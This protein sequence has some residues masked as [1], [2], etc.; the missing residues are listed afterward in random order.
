MYTPNIH[1]IRLYTQEHFKLRS[2]KFL[3][4]YCKYLQRIENFYDVSKYLRCDVCRWASR[5]R[6]WR[7]PREQSQQTCTQLFWLSK[8]CFPCLLKTWTCTFTNFEKNLSW[9]NILLHV[10][11][12][13]E[14]ALW[15]S[16]MKKPNKIMN[17]NGKSKTDM[18]V[19]WNDLKI[20]SAILSN[21]T[22]CQNDARNDG[23]SITYGKYTYIGR[24]LCVNQCN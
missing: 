3:T 15:I 19:H 4:T 1:Q 5:Q 10:N 16:M 14:I 13:M 6:R 2:L 12:L 8:T 23:K 24:N 21:Q 7:M 9:M 18:F 20:Y 11:M 22:T 17:N